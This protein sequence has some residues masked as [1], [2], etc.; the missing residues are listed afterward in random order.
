MIFTAG[1]SARAFAVLVVV[2]CFFFGLLSAYKFLGLIS[3]IFILGG[4]L[5][6]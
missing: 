4:G 1:A 6:S 5:V 2:V 3:T